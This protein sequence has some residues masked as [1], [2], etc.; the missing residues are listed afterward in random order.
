[1]RTI[2]QR[3]GPLKTV[4]MRARGLD[5]GEK[6]IEDRFRALLSEP[7][8]GREEEFWDS[9]KPRMLA[10][11]QRTIEEW[12]NIE[13]ELAVGGAQYY[14]HDELRLT[15]RSG[16]TCRKLQT[17]LGLIPRLWVPKVRKKK[18]KG[19]AIL[20]AYKKDRI[21]VDDLIKDVFLAGVSTRRVHEVL[22]P[23]LGRLY[24]AQLVS[25]SLKRL[26]A[27]VDVFHK[28]P[29][30][31][32]WHYLLFDGVVIK[33]RS[34]GKVR[35]KTVLVVKGFQVGEK[36]RILKEE[37]IDY[38]FAKGES[39]AAWEAF[40]NDLA[41]RGLEGKNLRM[42]ATDGNEGLLGAL[43]LVYPHTAKQRCWQH[44][45][46]NVANKCRRKYQALVVNS[47]REIYKAESEKQAVRAFHDF[48]RLVKPIQPEAVKCIEKD[49][50]ELLHFY[51]QPVELW[52][53]LRTTNS[54]ERSF[55]E[56]RRRIRTINVFSNEPSSD[57]ILYGVFTRLNE[58][59]RIR[60]SKIRK[61]AKKS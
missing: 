29:L 6:T 60:H 61:F 45:M 21:K 9:L 42:I 32:D 46:R 53:K 11:L 40:I 56:V 34:A 19:W 58:T 2:V 10:G 1:M 48:K 55:R 50:P 7:Q 51:K 13:T 20:K 49:L 39:T 15:H 57:R 22:K 30:S 23:V 38:R 47:A 28:R 25:N 18:K 3:Q 44:K 59:W 17:S 16:H 36:G 27:L 12:L 5:F 41:R 37:I 26:N 35:K 24:S 43:D 8:L 54:I 4:D 14:E 31:D 52:K 33:V